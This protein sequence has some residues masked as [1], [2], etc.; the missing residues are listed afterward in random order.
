MKIVLLGHTGFVG[1]NIGKLFTQNKIEY[2]GISKSNGYDLRDFIQAGNAL[3]EEKPDIIINCAAHVG[4][5]NYV[6]KMAAEVIL[7]I[8]HIL[9]IFQAIRKTYF[10]MGNF[11]GQFWPMELLG[12]CS[13]MF[14]KVLKCN[15]I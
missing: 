5:L 15:T 7:R 4:S 14:Q 1:K 11:I 2:S 12:V 8:V 13:L 6:T 10:G 9:L 3:L